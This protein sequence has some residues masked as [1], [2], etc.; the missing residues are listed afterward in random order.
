VD[1]R[2][3][4]SPN[5]PVLRRKRKRL[6]IAGDGFLVAFETGQRDAETVPRRGIIRIGGYC[7][8]RIRARLMV[9]PQSEARFGRDRH[10]NEPK[11]VA[12]ERITQTF[13][14]RTHIPVGPHQRKQ[15]NI[16]RDL[17]RDVSE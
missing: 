13:C 14:L 12:R 17:D 16:V 10:D 8:F 5:R 11:L 15:G 2:A 6:V 3:A 9:P 4:I 7:A 1:R